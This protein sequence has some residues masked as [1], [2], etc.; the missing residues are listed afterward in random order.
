VKFKFE[1]KVDFVVWSFFI[2]NITMTSRGIELAS[3]RK[4]ERKYA[5]VLYNY[6]ATYADELSLRLNDVVTIVSFSSTAGAGWWEARLRGK[7]G[8]IPDNFVEVIEEP[9][10]KPHSPKFP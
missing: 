1:N 2:F 8:K 7:T 3:S 10:G 5:R 6:T 4:E 9:T